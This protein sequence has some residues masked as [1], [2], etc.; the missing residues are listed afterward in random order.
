MSGGRWRKHRRV[1]VEGTPNSDMTDGGMILR[2]LT[3]THHTLSHTC[4]HVRDAHWENVRMRAYGEVLSVQFSRRRDPLIGWTKKKEI[5]TQP[6]LSVPP[7]IKPKCFDGLLVLGV[8]IM[9]ERVKPV[10]RQS[11]QVGQLT[12]HQIL[13]ALAWLQCQE[14]LR[15]SVAKE[16]SPTWYSRSMDSTDFTSVTICLVCQRL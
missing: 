6:L 8:A 3:K 11:S 1:G 4:N 2:R 9:V 16:P 10:V 7:R 14:V 5:A 12:M 13:W 15:R